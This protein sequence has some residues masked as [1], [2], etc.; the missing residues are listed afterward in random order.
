MERK[1]LIVIALCALL[2]GACGDDRGDDYYR[3]CAPGDPVD[4]YDCECRGNE[5]ICPSGGDCAIDCI[6]ACGLQ[7]AGS[8][9]CDFACGAACNVRCTGAGNCVIDVGDDSSVDCP[10]SGNCD[11]DCDGDCNV[12]C[13]QGTCTVFCEP[14]F[15][16]G[17]EGCPGSVEECPNDVLVCQRG[18]P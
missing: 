3:D 13:T 2:A 6:E 18:C 16:C 14:G 9:N 11:I 7:C 17:I 1:H 4:G 15:E 5:G 12:R 8:G 10:G